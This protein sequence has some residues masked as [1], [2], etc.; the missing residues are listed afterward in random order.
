LTASLP[1]NCCSCSSRLAM[2]RF[3]FEYLS[4]RDERIVPFVSAIASL[5]LFVWKK[6]LDDTTRWKR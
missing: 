4:Q 5:R 1:S 6:A 3:S 2:W